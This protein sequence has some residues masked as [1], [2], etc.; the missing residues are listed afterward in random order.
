MNNNLLKISF[1]FRKISLAVCIATFLC[2]AWKT[3]QLI[4]LYYSKAWFAEEQWSE[5][6]RYPDWAKYMFALQIISLAVLI[7]TLKIEKK[8]KL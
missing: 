7:I 1:V 5:V 2:L 3:G 8:N 6:F 4:S